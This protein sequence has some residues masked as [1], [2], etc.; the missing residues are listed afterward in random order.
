MEDICFHATSPQVGR[1]WYSVIIAGY[2]KLIHLASDPLCYE[3]EDFALWFVSVGDNGCVVSTT[4][5]WET[6][7]F[8]KRSILFFIDNGIYKEGDKE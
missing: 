2:D 1:R 8:P 4:A 7:Y 5:K 6:F 3:Q